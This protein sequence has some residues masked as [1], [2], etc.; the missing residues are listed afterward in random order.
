VWLQSWP[1]FHHWQL[2]RE[3]QVAQVV[4]DFPLELGAM[5]VLV[6]LLLREP[7]DIVLSKFWELHCLVDCLCLCAA[8]PKSA[9]V[10]LS[11]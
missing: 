6:E 2:V 5:V 4:W 1:P 3:A 7:F 9:P 11:F 10:A 8:I